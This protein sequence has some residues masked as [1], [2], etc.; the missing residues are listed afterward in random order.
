MGGIESM[1]EFIPVNLRAFKFEDMNQVLEIEE[2]AFPKTPYSKE[3]LLGFAKSPL[4]RFVVLEGKMH[5][6]GYI[7]YSKRGHLIST[8]VRRGERR[9]GFGRKL[10]RYALRHTGDE[11]LWLE[12]RSR[13]DSAIRF[14]K[15]VGMETIGKSPGYY[16]DDDALI[17]ISQEKKKERW[18]KE[19][20]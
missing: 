3:I 9:K 17:L 13:N 1:P 7:I 18:V 16:G 12:V 15:N 19:N 10:F 14:Y 2:Q 5:L 6:L 4:Y 11:R 8:A 20:E